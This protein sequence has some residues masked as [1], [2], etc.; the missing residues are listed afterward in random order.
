VRCVTQVREHSFHIE[1]GAPISYHDYDGVDMLQLNALKIHRL[2]SDHNVPSMEL[3]SENEFLQY[4]EGQEC[5][6]IQLFME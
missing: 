4:I 3:L 5:K 6:R 1:L 2:N